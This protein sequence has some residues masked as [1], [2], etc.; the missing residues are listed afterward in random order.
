MVKKLNDEIAGFQKSATLILCFKY[1]FQ[2]ID[3]M[4]KSKINERE[5]KITVEI[6]GGM[7]K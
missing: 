1:L 7:E 5:N 4:Q 3:I 6:D 2:I